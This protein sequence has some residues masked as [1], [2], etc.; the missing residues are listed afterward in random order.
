MASPTLDLC[1][2]AFL[3]GGPDRVVETA[4]VALVESGRVRVASPGQL[5]LVDPVRR[6]PVEGAVLDAVRTKGHRSVDLVVWRLAG[7][8]RIDRPVRGG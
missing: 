1:E 3:A 8:D 7:V 4:I 2:I 6:H 5:A